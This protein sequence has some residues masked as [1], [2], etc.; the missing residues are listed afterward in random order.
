M[1]NNSPHCVSHDDEFN[2]IQLTNPEPPDCS[3]GNF[4]DEDVSHTRQPLRPDN[5]QSS[6]SNLRSDNVQLNAK[7][8]KRIIK[9][10]DF[11]QSFLYQSL[12]PD[13]SLSNEFQ[14]LQIPSA[15]DE[16]KVVSINGVPHKILGSKKELI[17][18]ESGP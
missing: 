4:L 7:E 12:S 5:A 15:Y 10:N 11:S 17:P 18:L 1:D 9:P 6:V 3:N 8:E 2:L 16:D 14:A 13:A